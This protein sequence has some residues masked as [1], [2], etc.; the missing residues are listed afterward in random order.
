MK[1]QESEDSS[2]AQGGVRSWYYKVDSKLFTCRT[3][4]V[5]DGLFLSVGGSKNEH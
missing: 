4:P 2:G 3:A 1:H 5:V